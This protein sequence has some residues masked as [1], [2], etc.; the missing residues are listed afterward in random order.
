MMKA[1]VVMSKSSALKG[2]I[3]YIKGHKQSEEQATKALASFKKY[4]GWD[5]KLV[6]GLTANTAPMIAEFNNK[7]I[8]ESRL[9]NFKVENYD[10]FCTKMA[11]AINH[12]VFFREVVTADEPMVFLEH[13]AICLESWQSYEFDDYLC[14]N[15]EFVFRPPNKL[16]L[17]QFKKYNFPSFGVNDFPEDYP[18]LYHKNNIWKNS[19]MAPGTGAYAITPKGAKKML[20]AITTLGIDQSD[21][22]I[23]SSNVRMQ[24]IM[25]SPI[26]FNSVNLSTSYGYNKSNM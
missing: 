13:D 9:H 25:P 7:I 8:E 3:T 21:F 23:N 10:R 26:K 15:A 12:L 19:K 5:V 4:N 16:G 20:H 18:L 11:C 1:N 2:Q 6:E 24:Y 17:Q 22:M 14:L